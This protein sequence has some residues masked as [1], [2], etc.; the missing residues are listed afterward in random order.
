MKRRPAPRIVNLASRAGRL[1]K[2]YSEEM[3]NL[4]Q[5]STTTLSYTQLDDLMEDYI[6]STSNEK[7]KRSGDGDGILKMKMVTQDYP[8]YMKPYDYSKAGGM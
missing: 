1:D 5:S 6:T 4:F 7:K 3:K 2:K 8:F